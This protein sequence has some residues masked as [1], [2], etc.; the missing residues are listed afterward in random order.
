MSRRAFA[1]SLT[2]V[3]AG[4]AAA[5]TDPADFTIEQAA[6]LIRNKKLTPAELVGACLKRIEKHNPRLKAFIT[7]TGDE[8]L[9]PP[10]RQAHRC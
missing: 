7:V 6:E 5:A 1:A 8:A 4:A 9:K 2:A 3:S 10:R